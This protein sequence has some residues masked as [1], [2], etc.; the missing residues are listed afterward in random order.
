MPDER[1]AV[2]R[3]PHLNLIHRDTQSA[4][5]FGGG[6][7]DPRVTANK[8]NRAGH[9]RRLK[10]STE[11]LFEGYRQRAAARA[12]AGLPPIESGVP[13]AVEVPDN[14]DLDELVSHFGLDVVAED[15]PEM[16]EGKRRYVLVA[17]Q[18]IDELQLLRLIE[19]FSVRK[20]GCTA[21][22]SMLEILDDPQDPRRLDAILSDGLRS[23]WPFPPDE[24]LLL[25]VSFQTRGVLADLGVRPRKSRK[26]T[27]EEHSSRLAVWFSDNKA[28]LFEQW[29]NFG[30]LLDSEVQSIIRAY[31]GEVVKQWEDGP[32]GGI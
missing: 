15:S 12:A 29:D 30:L 22:A 6:K 7:P 23:R 16:S 32:W 4:R 3:F 31:R 5:F 9:S 20:R 25:D 1:P 13:F 18:K 14:F 19:G 17:A 8:L 26:E 2:D 10:K 24:G 11:D 21:V 27:H 28:R